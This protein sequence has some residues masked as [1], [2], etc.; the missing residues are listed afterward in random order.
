MPDIS[1]CSNNL[2]PSA[3]KCYRYMA[4]PSDWQSY[5]GYTVPKGEK[6]CDSFRPIDGRRIRQIKCKFL[7]R[8]GES[9]TANNN[10]IYPNCNQKQ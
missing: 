4:I 10:C 9:C 6:M 7:K 2:C 8:E 5:Q 3:G 1:M